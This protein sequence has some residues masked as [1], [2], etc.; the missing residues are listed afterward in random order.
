[1]STGSARPMYERWLREWSDI[2]GHLPRLHACAHG[3]C[4]EIGVRQGVSTSALLAGLE[5]HGGHLMSIDV[6]E[7]GH[8]FAGHPLWTFYRRDSVRDAAS[9]KSM[10]PVGLSLLFIDGDHAYESV[11]A[12]LTNYGDR[13]DCILLH[14]TE[15][16]EWR[17]GVCRAIKE[18]VAVNGRKVVWHTGSNGMAEVMW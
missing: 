1:M 5:E 12:D 8:L 2:Q 16:E 17:E 10:L 14:D 4:L 13:A 9:V 3:N 18:Y 11:L 15:A 6:D 7:C